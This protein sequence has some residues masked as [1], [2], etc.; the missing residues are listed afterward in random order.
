MRLGLLFRLYVL[1]GF[2]VV[3]TSVTKAA[4]RKVAGRRSRQVIETEP[5]EG[6]WTVWGE[7]SECSQ[8]CCVGASR[9][10]RKCLPPPPPQS[11]PLS[12][13]PPNWAGYLP[14]GIGGPVISPARPYYPPHYPGQHPP[15]HSPRSVSTNRE[16][17]QARRSSPI[18]PET[19][20]STQASARRPHPPATSTLYSTTTS[21][22]WG[23]SQAGTE[24]EE[25]LRSSDALAQRRS[26]AGASHR[27]VEEVRWTPEQSSARHLTPRSSWVASTT[28]SLSLR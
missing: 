22:T 18:R 25:L 14:R 6:V 20:S 8:T 19:G 23:S 24:A 7:W 2:V 15:Y 27:C 4:K 16:G 1:W 3:T 12:H 21:R 26:T 13:S 17:L 28:G 9:R 10:S 5:V 11:P